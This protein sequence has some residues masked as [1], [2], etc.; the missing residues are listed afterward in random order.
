VAPRHLQIIT[1][2]NSCRL[3]NIGNTDI[4]VATGFDPGTTAP[5]QVRPLTQ[6]ATVELMIGAWI[7][8]GDFTVRVHLQ[9]QPTYTP[10]PAPILQAP[11][12][13][14]APVTAATVG[15]T[16]TTA[17]SAQ[18]APVFAPRA[19]SPAAA[20]VTSAPAPAPAGPVG[21]DVPIGDNIGLRMNLAQTL[22]SV[23][24][25][26]EGSVVVRNAG[27]RPG[28]QFRLEIVGLEPDAYEIGPGPILFPNA[29]REV[30]FRLKHSGKTSPRAGDLRLIVRAT[31]PD[32]YPGQVAVATQTIQVAPV[33]KHAVK[34]TALD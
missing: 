5:T 4:T 9:E 26:L 32:A 13:P 27:N 30:G 12:V 19:P 15:A 11:V 22:L 6:L 2:D 10:A 7:K 8:L 23:D 3:V 18:T 20:P 17:T 16:A 31:A 25:P 21:P 14:V 33:Y 29:E 28:A 24:A 34:M 1:T